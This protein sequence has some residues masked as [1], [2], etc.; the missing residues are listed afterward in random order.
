MKL[1]KLD[2]DAGEPIKNKS[3]GKSKK[4]GLKKEKKG[5][6][7]SRAGWGNATRYTIKRARNKMRLG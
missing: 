2:N 6:N 7:K 4:K 1:H 5:E 3:E